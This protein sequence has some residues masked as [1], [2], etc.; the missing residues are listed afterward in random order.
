MVVAFWHLIQKGFEKAKYL[1]LTIGLS[2]CL[3]WFDFLL[4]MFEFTNNI[5]SWDDISKPWSNNN[6]NALKAKKNF[7]SV[8][9]VKFLLILEKIKV[10]GKFIFHWFEKKN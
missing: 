2:S 10:E 7:G 8:R 9:W 3:I 4:G 6:H 1:K 5:L